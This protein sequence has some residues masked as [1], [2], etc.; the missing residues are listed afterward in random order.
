MHIKVI[1][2]LKCKQLLAGNILD[3]Y[4]IKEVEGLLTIPDTIYIY[5][6]ISIIYG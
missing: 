4:C 2:S 6:Y 5:I 1:Q 3:V